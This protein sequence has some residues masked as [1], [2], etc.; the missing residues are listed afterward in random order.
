VADRLR[1][2]IAAITLASLA[3]CSFAPPYHPAITPTPPAFKEA[4][5][6]QPAVAPGAIVPMRYRAR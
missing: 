2:A 4:G 3:G 5:A 1:A 6:W